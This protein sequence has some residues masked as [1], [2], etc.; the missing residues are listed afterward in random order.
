MV[1]WFSSATAASFA[2]SAGGSGLAGGRP[3]S[4]WLDPP[5]GAGCG[6][7]LCLGLCFRYLGVLLLFRHEDLVDARREVPQAF[8]LVL[9]ELLV[10]GPAVTDHPPLESPGEVFYRRVPPR[11]VLEEQ[12]EMGVADDPHP[13]VLP[14]E[15]DAVSSTCVKSCRAAI[16]L[17]WV[18]LPGGRPRIARTTPRWRGQ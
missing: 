13:P 8:L 18:Q 17:S 5:E 16:S 15:G 4:S 1:L 14:L 11:L 10:C 7:L 9:F 6:R 2:S 3:A 12:C